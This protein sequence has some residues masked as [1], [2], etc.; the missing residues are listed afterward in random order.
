MPQLEGS[1]DGFVYA[2]ASDRNTSFIFDM[3]ALQAEVGSKHGKYTY[4]ELSKQFF[5]EFKQVVHMMNGRPWSV[6]GSFVFDG[7]K[8]ETTLKAAALHSPSTYIC[9]RADS[10]FAHLAFVHRH[11]L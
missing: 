4:E 2:R 8:S 6:V 10:C 9:W 7:F 1:V 5:L 3:I 11:L